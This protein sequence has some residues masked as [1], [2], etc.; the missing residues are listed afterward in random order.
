MIKTGNIFLDFISFL[1]AVFPLLPVV[2]VFIK[3]NYYNE[4]LN[5]LMILCLLNFIKNILLFVIDINTS[6]QN[7][8][9]NIFSLIEFI[10][11]FLI[12]KN[13]ASQ[14]FWNY[15]N[16]CF[17]VFLSVIITI[18]LLRGAENKIF[19]IE[20]FQNAIIVSASI[21]C[22]IKLAY[23]D[24]LLIFNQPLLWIAI[25]SL[26]YFSI[27]ILLQSLNKVYEETPNENISGSMLLLNIGSTARYFFYLLA[28]FFHEGRND[29]KK[30]N[31]S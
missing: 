10:I 7:I 22:I 19:V 21:L 8:I 4:S 23:S 6:S 30:K 9:A 13:L 16:I 17:S 1:S 3:K 18:Y 15:I 24:S 26:F 12:F 25:G 14:K 11:L 29:R 20:E 5:F 31:L 28:A 27:A 2:V